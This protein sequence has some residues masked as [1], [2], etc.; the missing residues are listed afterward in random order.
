MSLRLISSPVLI[1]RSQAYRLSNHDISQHPP[2]SS[3]PDDV[4]YI[5]KNI[6]SRLL[7]TGSLKT[8]ERTLERLRDIID[9][10]YIGVVKR[11]LDDVYRTGSAPGSSGRGEKV[12]RGGAGT[13][14]VAGDHALP[15]RSL[16]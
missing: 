1:G 7:S 13:S 12:E 10:D 14:A 4:F 16:I 6:L 3:A 2:T 9:R 5:L 8:V 11:K 15:T